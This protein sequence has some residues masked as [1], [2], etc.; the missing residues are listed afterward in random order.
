MDR[1]LLAKLV[2]GIFGTAP[3]LSL[4]SQP[5]LAAGTDIASAPL[6]NR[7]SSDIKPN[8]MLVLDDSGSMQQDYM[9]DSVS[10]NDAYGPGYRNN[11]CNT[12][13]YNPTPTNPSVPLSPYLAPRTEAGVNL[14]SADPAS[15]S[16]A[17]DN[18]FWSYDQVGVTSGVADRTNLAA[19]QG[20]GG[21]FPV[22]PSGQASYYWR[23]LGTNP[24]SVTPTSE[25]CTLPSLGYGNYNTASGV[26]SSV[27]APPY[28]GGT[29]TLVD[30]ATTTTPTDAD[31]LGDK[32]VWEKVVVS[33]TSSQESLGSYDERQR[34]AN[35]YSYYRNR[36]QMTKSAIGR[37]FLPLIGKKKYRTG[38][39]TIAPQQLDNGA[40]QAS[41]YGYDAGAPHNSKFLEIRNFDTTDLATNQPFRWYNILYAQRPNGA[42]PLREGLSRV[43]RY[44][45][46][47]N[48]G[49]NSGMIPSNAYDP[50][51][52]ACQQNFSI[53]TTDGYWDSPSGSIGGFKLIHTS[54]MDN[55]DGNINETASYVDKLGVTQI[56]AIGARP[57]YD[58]TA[59][60]TATTTDAYN[61]YQNVFCN[62]Y[63]ESNKLITQG[64][65]QNLQTTEQALESITQELQTTN[66]ALSTTNQNLQDTTQVLQTALQN[67]RTT[68]QALRTTSQT[69]QNTRQ[70]AR[71]QMQ[72]LRTTNQALTTTTQILLSTTQFRRIELQQQVDTLQLKRNTIQ[73]RQ[74]TAQALQT[75]RQ[76]L[77]TQNQALRTI[78]QKL[79]NTTQSAQSR[80]QRLR[81]TNQALRTTNQALRNTAQVR[82]GTL[83]LLQNTSQKLQDTA[84]SLRSTDQAFKT[85]QQIRRCNADGTCTP[86]TPVAACTP[87]TE[88]NTCTTI[89][90][91]PTAASCTA[92][93]ASAGN[94]WITTTCAVS[95]TA[96]VA[97]ASCAPVSASAGNSWVTTTCPT[98]VTASNVPVSSCSAVSASAGNSWVTTTCPAPVTTSNVPAASCSA[99]GAS[100]GN[101]W[102]TTTC[103]A[104][105]IATSNVPVSACTAV[106]AS[107]GNNWVTTSCSNVNTSNV[108]VSSCSATSA[109]A[110][111][112]WITTSCPAPT[113]AA[114]N[115][116]V[117]ACTPVSASSGNS[118]VT[119][120]C[121]APTIASSNVP[122]SACAATSA[123]A[124]NSWITTT[125]P[126]PTIAT[127]NVGVS[128]CTAVAASAGNSW[129]TTICSNIVTS[130]VALGSCSVTSA[131]AGNSWVATSCPA[132][133]IAA[134]NIPVSACTP[135]SASSGNSWVT[136]TC[137]APTIAS[138]NV[139][140]SSCAAVSASAGNSWVTTSCSTAGASNVPVSVC[141]AVSA[142]AG[143]SW[144]TTSCSNVTTS[145]VGVSSCSAT[146]ASAGNS[147]VSTTCP[148]P[149][150]TSNVP[151][152]ACAVVA[153][154]SGNSWIATTAC[155]A[156]TTGPTVISACNA[157]GASAGNSWVTTNCSSVILS[158]TAVSSCV[159]VAASAGNSWVTTLCVTVTTV[160]VGVS[161]CSPV[162]A[163]AGNSWVATLCATSV[164][165]NVATASCAPVSASA[166]NSWI[167]TTCP[168]PTIAASNV[169]VSA[170]TASSASA[171]NS[172]V[173]TTCPAPTIA[174]S[175]VGVS[176][177]TAAAAAAGNSWVTTSCSNIT[178]SNIPVAACAS[179]SASAGNSWI[180][181]TCPAPTI[182]PSNVPVSACTPV[183]ASAGNFWVTTACPA[184]TI[185]ASN[186][187]VASCSAA[188]ASAG[189]SWVTTT[190]P[191]PTIASSNVPVSA[192][193]AASASPGNSWVTTTCSNVNTS[194]VAISAC[195]ATSASAGNS[196]VATSCPTPTIAASNVPVSACTPASASAGNSWVTT[197][198][199]APTIAAS[200][201]PVAA[202]N[203]T[204]ASA[205]NNW[206]TTTCPAPTIATSNVPVAACAPVSASA[207]NNWV[208]TSCPASSIAASNTGVSACNVTGAS[209]GNA[210]V[211]TTCPA[212]V[213]T[214]DVPVSA[215]LA[216]SGSA[217]NAWVLATCTTSTSA[218]TSVQSCT[219]MV[220]SA[221]NSFISTECDPQPGDKNQYQTSIRD[222]LDR[223]SDTVLVG[224]T[225]YPASWPAPGP[226]TDM[227][228]CLPPGTVPALLTPG[229]PGPTDPATP[230]YTSFDPACTGWPCTHVSSTPTGGS[231]NSLADVAQYYY[232]TDLRPAG[233][234]GFN[235]LDVS[236]DI[237]P[238]SGTD[239]I[240][241]DK[242]GWQH[243]TTFTMGLGVSGT[244]A[245]NKNYKTKPIGTF[246]TITPG[247]P[248]EDFQRIRCQDLSNATLS[249]P[250]LCSNWPT[251]VPRDPGPP[252]VDSAPGTRVDDLW[253]AAVDGRGQYFSAADP[254]AV[255]TGLQTALL[256]INAQAGSGTG[257]TTSTQDPIPGNDLTFRAGFRTVEWTGD[258][259]AQQL[260]TG[261]DL[262]LEGTT[263]PGIVWSAQDKLDGQVGSLCDNRTIHL[264]RMG[265]TNNLTPF[266]WNSKAC[267]GFGAPT[268]AASTG[269]N[270]AEQDYLASAAPAY[271]APFQM[272]SWS[273]FLDMTD[274][275][276][277][278][279]QRVLAQGANLVNFLRGQRGMEDFA[280][281]SATQLFRKRIHVL[282]DIVGS[283]PRFVRP[284]NAQFTDLGYALFKAKSGIV[285]RP[286][287]LYA[288]ANDGMLHAFNVGSSVTDVNGGKELWAMVPSAVL[289][290]LYRLGDARYAE[291]H[292]YFVDSTASSG[293]I[294]DKHKIVPD[295]CAGATDPLVARDCWKTVLIGG[296]GAGGR[297]YY[298]MDVTNPAS[299]KALWEFKWSDTC[300]DVSSPATHSADCHIGLTFGAPLITKLVDGTWVALVSSGMNNINSPIKAGDGQ[301]YLYVLDA[302]TGKIL[303]KVGTGVGS[304]AS[305]TATLSGT[306][307]LNGSTAVSGS[308]TAFT[309]QLV[310][311]Q[312]II[313]NGQSRVVQTIGDDTNLTVTMAFSGSGPFTGTAVT[314][315]GPADFAYVNAYIE[316]FIQNN[317]AER[318]YGGDRLG[319]VWRIN[320]MRLTD[321]DDPTSAE[322]NYDVVKLATLL[323]PNG[324]P[325]P[326]STTPQMMNIGQA[327]TRMVY[328]GT[329]RYLG[330][331]DLSDTQVQT[332]YGIG[333]NLTLRSDSAAYISNG[334]TVLPTA[335]LTLRQQ[336]NQV[337]LS[338]LSG[339][340]NTRQA[341]SPVCSAA[342]A[343]AGIGCVGWYVDLPTPG[344][345]VNLDM[346]L[347]LGSLIVPSN[348]TNLS[349][350]DTGGNSWLNVFDAATGGEVP[351][352]PYRAGTYMPGAVTV[353]IS[354]IRG[355]SGRIMSILTKSDDTQ[356]VTEVQT[357]QGAPLG[358]RSGWRDLLD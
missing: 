197:A 349:A 60:S 25:I 185:A 160:P 307:T 188:S 318:V 159:A 101:N 32:L 190:C 22:N 126:A 326:I 217:G 322:V 333:E 300:Y 161:S 53:L 83:Q 79:R 282:G 241:G 11:L 156:L 238:S 317:T 72:R 98:P 250:N 95:S 354:L 75:T 228:L 233:T 17:Y 172:W 4:V 339:D 77:R 168:A 323:D 61:D 3:F 331:S 111:N 351:G 252:A 16:A 288:G 296:L 219:P 151:V 114:S 117:S 303:K 261:T 220:A 340:P 119:T 271:N 335:P 204:S 260:Y 358:R 214:A 266:T 162:A 245:Y 10:S 193:S 132:P 131:S 5:A 74:N 178:S 224:S 65:T 281:G 18:G 51:Q 289:P 209:A 294:Y 234:T 1:K 136:T 142:S 66:Q 356:Q 94:S 243:M 338:A 105:T 141:A 310:Q 255:F 118:W 76:R 305:S 330:E 195:S 210:W 35:W 236:S 313:V 50:V 251:P 248:D 355:R 274:G 37:A 81:T 48:D 295:T 12:I 52:Y 146:S 206:V 316:N 27:T 103:P 44:S 277:G 165:A 273:Q 9:P 353:G 158:S 108:A 163:S 221:G 102:I 153:A 36:M 110:G 342:A 264:L 207:G 336:L 145:N 138:S 324:N 280:S 201:V 350:C 157:I 104:P 28:T 231:S 344:E 63:L 229:R 175:N 89:T 122:V 189:N 135:V 259:R 112:S 166:G 312:T 293:D 194:N 249:D 304:A 6:A 235:G 270:A 8:I 263:L 352:S 169:P 67:L 24:N 319:N 337:V 208:T 348:V 182:V 298:A 196:W 258:I 33:A 152:S 183:G 287:M 130:N 120:T 78:N 244:F 124:G 164:L 93:S 341:A 129:V 116:P 223:Y 121:P 205:G 149:V 167:T 218:A 211:T 106:S 21:S 237:V 232:K 139:A 191:A 123:S 212:P 320:L 184:S 215:C 225:A 99:T 187:P 192:C 143:N 127:S 314:G 23:Y 227:T 125:C 301:G 308:G 140:V 71:S 73:N 291:A 41:V 179:T 181:T 265:A 148:A 30:E 286:T 186:I 200:N 107:A 328:V 357:Q 267:D 55:Q 268:G 332:I 216:T 109:S 7:R 26:C 85:T 57:I 170:C 43:G 97:V 247:K 346:R 302:I 171:G 128:A 155:S 91:G 40:P 38:F 325:Q 70:S 327:K 334:H 199:P 347:V 321:P 47:K 14:N 292:T 284:P 69:L 80:T 29:Y 203:A 311:G 15:F 150:V 246:G 96:N 275:T 42:T 329:G 285:D 290:S 92:V 86:G 309:G 254:D 68:D 269:L 113:I 115:V 202:C 134:S 253:H 315:T 13:Y 144:V 240:E 46:G 297:G 239:P 177:C 278:V 147:W 84:Q 56:L 88:V 279:D 257:A 59:T 39:I 306:L 173:T 20:W 226:W 174:T 49:P 54:A 62:Y 272:T 34:F 176:S 87:T 100:A 64:T 242:A 283:Q 180:T 276:N 262:A 90:T 31:C 19:D 345:R 137:P 58:G 198:C 343:A 256:A 299:P 82:Q 133:T 2:A 222:R 230:P 154:S 213:V 45:A